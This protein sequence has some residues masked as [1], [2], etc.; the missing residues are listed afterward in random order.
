[1]GSAC[2]EPEITAVV[3]WR[4][5]NKDLCWLSVP[6]CSVCSCWSLVYTECVAMRMSSKK[7]H[8]ASRITERYARTCPCEEYSPQQGVTSSWTTQNA[9]TSRVVQIVQYLMCDWKEQK[10][11]NV[12]SS[13]AWPV[14]F[15]YIMTRVY[16]SNSDGM[17]L[18]ITT[19]GGIFCHQQQ[20]E[21][22]I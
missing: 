8:E 21:V 16:A 9:H 11:H 14:I 7:T 19:S 6:I 17:L 3:K 18:F 1:M 20:A 5:V 10:E 13:V 2:F 22:V 15:S 4:C 12:I